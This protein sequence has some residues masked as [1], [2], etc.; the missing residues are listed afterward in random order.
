M[1]AFTHLASVLL[2][3]VYATAQVN[4]DS[5]EEPTNSLFSMF[6]NSE[7]NGFDV[8]VGAQA[9]TSWER[10]AQEQHHA[11]APVAEQENVTGVND[12]A[13]HPPRS[14][15]QRPEVLLK[16]RLKTLLKEQRLVDHVIE[17][18]A[19]YLAMAPTYFLH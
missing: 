1:K 18:C 4:I 3:T 13:S 9:L 11:H 6:M 19:T 5:V 14:S 8:N 10:F 16:G 15:K 17:V 2:L 7:A 12:A